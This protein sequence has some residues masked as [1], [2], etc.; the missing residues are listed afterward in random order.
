MERVVPEFLW[1]LAG[2]ACFIGALIFGGFCV[3]R[4]LHGDPRFGGSPRACVDHA[5]PAFLQEFA[6]TAGNMAPAFFWI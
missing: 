5:A 1:G 3:P 4:V 2:P 6:G